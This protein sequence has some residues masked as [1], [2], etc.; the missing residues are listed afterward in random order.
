MEKGKKIPHS[1]KIGLFI[2]IGLICFFGIV[3]ITDASVVCSDFFKG[4]FDCSTDECSYSGQK[5]C[6][7]SIRRQICGNYDSDPGLEWSPLKSCSGVTS[8]GYGRCD[9]D[10][11]PKWYCLEGECAY[12]CHYD[13]NCKTSFCECSTGACCDGCNYKTTASI[14]DFEIQTQYGCPWGTACGADTA[15]RTRTKLKYCSGNSPVCTGGWTNWFNWSGW[16]TVDICKTTEVCKVGN[17]QCQYSSSCVEPQPTADQL[18]TGY[19]AY[20]TGNELMILLLGRKE[21]SSDEWKKEI[22]ANWGEKIDFLLVVANT[23]QQD[24]NNVMVKV[25]IPQEIIYQG[26]LKIGENFSEENI[27]EGLNVG[28][29]SSGTM[30]T[31]TFKGEVSSG[32]EQG[33][34]DVVGTANI[35]DLSSSDS[36]KI[37]F[38]KPAQEAAQEQ[39]QEQIAAAA[40][41]LKSLLR[42][43]YFWVLLVLGVITSFYLIKALSSKKEG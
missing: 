12:N 25:E 35:E 4:F 41:T 26:D 37:V 16:R 14:C 43:W 42:K 19:T 40:L 5:R 24:F 9:N 7:D 18:Q 13:S 15:K 17:S 21:D 27:N 34:R 33:Q 39:T 32:V 36:I 8:C 22:K 3:E 29:F 10:Q 6:I 30:K 2:A 23:C 1:L 38:E 20:D 11:R 28:F 31:I